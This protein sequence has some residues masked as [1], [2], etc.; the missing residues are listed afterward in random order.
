VSPQR[1]C[2]DTAKLNHKH[3]TRKPQSLTMDEIEVG[4]YDESDIL[5]LF[6][7]PPHC[8]SHLPASELHS[9]ACIQLPA[10]TSI[11]HIDSYGQSQPSR[12]RRLKEIARRTLLKQYTITPISEY[13]H[14][15]AEQY[16]TPLRPKMGMKD[17]DD[18]ITARAANPRTGL[19][20]PSLA[21][22]PRTPESPAEALKL[23]SQRIRPA[24]TRA[25]EARKISAGG[26]QRLC[27]SEKGWSFEDTK[28]S[29]CFATA[30]RCE[31]WRCRHHL[32]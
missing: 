27:S 24:L 12:T 10:M 4:L 14:S 2:V 19:I 32:L 31:R 23:R 7:R 30:E 21:G 29:S 26:L 3:A 8:H 5:E 17:S 18:Y 11:N 25:N 9:R 6:A 13:R 1:S 28:I 20:S 16:Q 15:P 22:T